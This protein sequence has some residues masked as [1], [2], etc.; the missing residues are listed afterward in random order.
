MYRWRSHIRQLLSRIR[1][2][3]VLGKPGR[4]VLYQPSA[5]ALVTGSEMGEVVVAA[6]QVGEGRIVVLSQ[7]IYIKNIR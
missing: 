5:A 4:L 2:F 1:S 3:P 6:G 7:D